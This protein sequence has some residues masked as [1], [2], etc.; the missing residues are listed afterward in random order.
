VA[1][2]SARQG[3]ATVPGHAAPRRAA[4][5]ASKSLCTVGHSCLA[6]SQVSPVT[7]E[8]LTLTTIKITTKTHEKLRAAGP[9]PSDTTRAGRSALRSELARAPATPGSSAEGS[10]GTRSP[11][12]SCPYQSG[13]ASRQRLWPMPSPPCCTV[14]PHQSFARTRGRPYEKF[15]VIPDNPRDKVLHAG[16]GPGPLGFQLNN[17]SGRRREKFTAAEVSGNITNHVSRK[18]NITN[19]AAAG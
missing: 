15:P 8:A 14:V 2:T 11:L 18:K 4:Q 12:G 17:K 7:T 13:Q 6:L 5:E 16:A 3:N 19:H 1:G 9:F 10:R